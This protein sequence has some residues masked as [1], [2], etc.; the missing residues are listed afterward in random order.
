MQ[1]VL[2]QFCSRCIL[3]DVLLIHIFP[4]FLPVHWQICI[5][6]TNLY[7]FGQADI[8]SITEKYHK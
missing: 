5:Y 2:N 6:I 1:L 7:I 3:P 8:E 4:V